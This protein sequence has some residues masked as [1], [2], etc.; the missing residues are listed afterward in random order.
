MSTQTDVLEVLACTTCSAAH[1]EAP[2]GRCP[3]CGASDLTTAVLAET[4][5][6]VSTTTVRL[7]PPGVEVP[8]VLAYAD[9]APGARL[10]AR[11]EAP[12]RIGD[13]VRLREVD[14]EVERFRFVPEEADQ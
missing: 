4:G 5:T 6:V 2:S 8:Y 3:S 11:S 13:A 12:L 14:D 1:L 10:I 9:F 7:A